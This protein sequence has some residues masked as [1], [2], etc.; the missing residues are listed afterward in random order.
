[1]KVRAAGSEKIVE[2]YAVLDG[3]SNT[4]FC[5]ENLLE[6]M[7]IKG[8]RR[9]LSVTILGNANSKIESSIVTLELSGLQDKNSISLKPHLSQPEIV[10]PDK[11]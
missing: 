3:G 11:I 6:Q 5:T 10:P 1:V 7:G 9:S 2:T 4:S 8:K